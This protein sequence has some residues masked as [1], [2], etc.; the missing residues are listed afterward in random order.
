MKEDGLYVH[1]RIQLLDRKN[2]K[3]W[4]KNWTYDA[5]GCLS[6]LIRGTATGHGIEG[7]AY[8]SRVHGY[9]SF[10]DAAKRKEKGGI[11]K[12]QQSMSVEAPQSQMPTGITA[13]RR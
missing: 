10:P 8:G 2:D 9:C 7:G 12:G 5:E 11:A 4:K 13:R 3:F 1:G 6:L